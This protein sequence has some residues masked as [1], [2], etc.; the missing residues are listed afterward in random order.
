MSSTSRLLRVHSLN[1]H[2]NTRR[3]GPMQASRNRPSQLICN[4]LGLATCA[5]PVGMFY[6]LTYL[7][8]IAA[9]RLPTA[10]PTSSEQPSGGVGV[11]VVEGASAS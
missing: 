2:G 6:L 7:P 8:S 9:Q 4:P 11:V 3:A 1:P 5:L 10:G